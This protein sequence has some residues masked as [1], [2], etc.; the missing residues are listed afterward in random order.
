MKHRVQ[1]LLVDKMDKYEGTVQFEIN[2]N[3]Y[4]AF[5]YGEEYEPGQDIEV[6][7]D[8]LE[9]PLEWSVIFNENK[10]K[11]LRL[12]KSKNS[13]WSYYGYG[14]IKTIAPVIADFGDIQLEL[15]NW[16]NDPNVIGEFIYWTIDRLDISTIKE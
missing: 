1:I 15:G 11:K 12:E 14:K 2:G 3:D 8:H 9:T 6:E 5:F 16:T 4:K 7:L 10:D 13:E